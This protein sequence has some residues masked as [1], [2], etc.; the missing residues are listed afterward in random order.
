M[1]LNVNVK[2]EFPALLIIHG[3]SKEK[4]NIPIIGIE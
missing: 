4:N 3:I 2:W 1:T